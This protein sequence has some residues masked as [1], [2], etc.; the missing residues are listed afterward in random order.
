MFAGHNAYRFA[1]DPFYADGFIPTVR[2]LVDR[3]VTGN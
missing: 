3:L 1:R 2:Q